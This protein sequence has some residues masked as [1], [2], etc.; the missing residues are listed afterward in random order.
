[1][2]RRDNPC[3]LLADRRS[4]ILSVTAG[5]AAYACLT[6]R[7]PARVAVTGYSVGEMAA[8]SVAGIWNAATALQLT[9]LRARA[10]D[11][12][13]GTGGR[14]GYVRGMLRDAVEALAAAHRC[15]IAII[16]LSDLFV[17]GG[18]ARDVEDLCS[19]AAQAKRAGLLDVRIASHTAFLSGA[20]APFREALERSTQAA[21]V[22]RH[23]LLA[24]GESTKS[25]TLD[26]DMPSSTRC[27]VLILQYQAIPSPGFARSKV[28]EPG[29]GQTDRS[30]ECGGQKLIRRREVD[31]TPDE[32]P[33]PMQHPLSMNGNHF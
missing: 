11:E 12:A 8:W 3:I 6:D 2:I 18:A 30:F 9:D 27:A 4:Q 23:V 22:P 19:A 24:G 20:V 33:A 31:V 10:M 21:P 15:A 17:I 1:M 32:Q 29:S 7:F 13:G 5:L 16:A 28:S 25:W 26:Q 14:P